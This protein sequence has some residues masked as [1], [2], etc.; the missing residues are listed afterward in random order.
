ESI[1]NEDIN[2]CYFNVF[3]SNGSSYM[4]LDEGCYPYV[5]IISL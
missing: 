5:D 1:P 2:N 4:C 3:Y